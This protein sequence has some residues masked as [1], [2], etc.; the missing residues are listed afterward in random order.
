MN[1]E[2]ARK[3]FLGIGMEPQLFEPSKTEKNFDLL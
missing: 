2:L 3:S 1:P